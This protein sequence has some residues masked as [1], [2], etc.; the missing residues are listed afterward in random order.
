MSIPVGPIRALFTLC[1]KRFALPI[2]PVWAG[3]C[4]S[5]ACHAPHK[6]NRALDPAGKLLTGIVKPDHMV[7]AHQSDPVKQSLL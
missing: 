2:G 6:R 4:R 3:P 1:H 7:K 5:I